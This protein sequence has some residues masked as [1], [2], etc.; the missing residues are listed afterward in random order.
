MEQLDVFRVGCQR[1][2]IEIVARLTH[3][4]I[5]QTFRAHLLAQVTDDLAGRRGDV[6]ITHRMAGCK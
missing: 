6:Q 1:I 3:S 2:T 4:A 5:L